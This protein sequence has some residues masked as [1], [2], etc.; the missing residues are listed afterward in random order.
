MS[1][2]TVKVAVPSN[3]P[4]GLDAGL[5]GHF[6]HCDCF[7]LVEVSD[8]KLG[9]AEVVVNQDHAGDCFAPINLLVGQ[10]AGAIVVLGMGMRPLMGFRQAGID[11]FFGTGDTVRSCVEAF[12][13]GELSPFGARQ[14]CGGGGGGGMP[15][16]RGGLEGAVRGG[17]GCGGRG[18][19]RRG[20]GGGRGSR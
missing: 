5:S 19:G 11:V 16:G 15:G 20:G 1:S 2:Q 17:G 18:G 14:V 13:R 12:A 7:T 9:N 6:G 4:G 3:A 8:G 10:G